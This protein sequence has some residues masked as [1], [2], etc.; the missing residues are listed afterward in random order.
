M[1]GRGASGAPTGT[2]AATQSAAESGHAS[3]ARQPVL[4]LVVLGGRREGCLIEQHDVRLVV[5]G[6]LEATIPELRRQWRG[7]RQG[8]HIDSWVRLERLEGFWLRLRPEPSAGPERLWFVNIGGYDPA[9]LAEQHAFGLFV[10]GS[11]QAARAKARRTLLRE[12]TQQHKDDLH[13]VDDC[14][15][16][17][18]LQGWWVHLERE[19]G[20]RPQPPEPLRPDWFG[21]RRIDRDE[22]EGAALS[23]GDPGA[24]LAQGAACQGVRPERRHGRPEDGGGFPGDA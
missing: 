20:A 3:E 11:P 6:S 19:A 14:L 1:S 15:A 8:L 9:Q 21:Y 10:A 24:A 7:R 2:M 17:G 22:D 16:V 13:A 23:L 18:Q 12:V 4:F 5:G